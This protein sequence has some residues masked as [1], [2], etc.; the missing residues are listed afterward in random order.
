M[1]MSREQIKTTVRGLASGRSE[2]ADLPVW[3]SHQSSL[4]ERNYELR[5]HGIGS[6]CA[7]VLK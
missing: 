2:I 1:A 5:D 7:I 4:Q 3:Q 6:R